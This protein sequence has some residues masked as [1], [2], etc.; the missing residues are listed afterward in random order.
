LPTL[1]D[2]VA[3]D[4]VVEEVDPDAVAAGVAE[5]DKDQQVSSGHILRMTNDSLVIKTAELPRHMEIKITAILMDGTTHP[6]VTARTAVTRTSFM[7]SQQLLR[8]PR[9]VATCTNVSP[10]EPEGVGSMMNRTII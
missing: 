6:I 3:V 1:P 7:T 4:A 8:T 9:M 10:T 5:V 2:E